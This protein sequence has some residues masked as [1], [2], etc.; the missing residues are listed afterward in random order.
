MKHTTFHFAI[1]TQKLSNV[2]CVVL[3]RAVHV[4]IRSRGQAYKTVFGCLTLYTESLPGLKVISLSQSF[5]SF[6]STV[7][8]HFSGTWECSRRANKEQNF[9]QSDFSHENSKS[10]F[11]PREFSFENS[12]VVGNNRPCKLS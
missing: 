7:S 10:I 5:S 11:V 1:K 8:I 9:E 3:A 12:R 6:I 2:F 4:S